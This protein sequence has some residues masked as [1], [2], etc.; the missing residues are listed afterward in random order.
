LEVGKGNV[1]VLKMRKNSK[2]MAENKIEALSYR[3]NKR[4]PSVYEL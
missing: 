3:E 2:V 1:H 4:Y